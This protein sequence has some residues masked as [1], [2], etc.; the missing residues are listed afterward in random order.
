VPKGPGSKVQGRVGRSTD[1]RTAEVAVPA[2][3]ARVPSIGSRS[4]NEALAARR[5]LERA[6]RPQAREQE[7]ST[8]WRPG[9][10]PAGLVP[11]E[12]KDEASGSVPY[13]GSDGGDPAIAESADFDVG[14]VRGPAYAFLECDPGPLGRDEG[15]RTRRDGRV[16]GSGWGRVASIAPSNGGAGT[17]GGGRYNTELVLTAATVVAASRSVQARW[18][19]AYAAPSAPVHTAV[20]WTGG[21][22]LA[23]RPAAAAQFQDVIQ[24]YISARRAGHLVR[25]GP[26]LPGTE[27][28][29]SAP[30]RG[31]RPKPW[32][33][34]RRPSAQFPGCGRVQAYF[35]GSR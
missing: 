18:T 7:G 31:S 30:T 21:P 34:V 23:D 12:Q 5:S 10:V 8:S 27:V 22:G 6:P 3:A 13:P 25:L 24:R 16:R 17:S 11:G 29:T 32:S 28:D 14:E 19:G 35:I 20:G 2:A 33:P 15:S 26:L 1:L 4:E 9:L